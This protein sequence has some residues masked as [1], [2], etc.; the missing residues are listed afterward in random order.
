MDKDNNNPDFCKKKF[1]KRLTNEFDGEE[2]ILYK[3]IGIY[4][5]KSASYLANLEEAIDRGH[6]TE[7][8]KTSHILKSVIGNFTTDSPFII[9]NTIESSAK[10]GKLTALSKLLHRLKKQLALLESA[11]I[12]LQPQLIN[13]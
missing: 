3:L 9:L 7:I 5:N 11:L 12:E 2:E 8:V 13:R 1:T 10:E 4:Q 6:A